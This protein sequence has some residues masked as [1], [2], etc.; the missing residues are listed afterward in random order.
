MLYLINEKT[1]AQRFV[2]LSPLWH[3]KHPSFS[4]HWTGL[5]VGG[6]WVSNIRNSNNW[7]IL[8]SHLL[9]IEDSFDGFEPIY[10]VNRSCIWKFSEFWLALEVGWSVNLSTDTWCIGTDKCFFKTNCQWTSTHVLDFFTPEFIWFNGIAAT[11]ACNLY[12]M[13]YFWGRHGHFAVYSTCR[14]HHIVY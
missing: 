14:Y 12:K 11:N 1:R 13:L 4:S 5:L 10:E 9:V 6:A 2:L 7:T 3:R 8:L